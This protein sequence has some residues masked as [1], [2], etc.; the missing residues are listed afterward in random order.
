MQR[1]TRGDVI[2]N[3]HEARIF[4][5]R[6]NEECPCGRPDV[7]GVGASKEGDREGKRTVFEVNR[8]QRRTGCH[9]SLM[10]LR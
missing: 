7:K 5:K 10:D 3:D 2:S 6:V 8:S 1:D 4:G 9:R